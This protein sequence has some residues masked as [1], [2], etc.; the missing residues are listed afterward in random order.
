MRLVTWVV[1][2]GGTDVVLDLQHVRQLDCTG[3]GLLVLAR[4][5]LAQHGCPMALANVERRQRRLL[6][7]AGLLTVLP[8]FGSRQDAVAWC[9]RAREQECRSPRIPAGWLVEAPGQWGYLFDGA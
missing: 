2:H 5:R 6:D 1:Q 8:V 7:L 4:N 9:R 3:L